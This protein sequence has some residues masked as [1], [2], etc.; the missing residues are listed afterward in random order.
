MIKSFEDKIWFNCTFE[1][2]M[3]LLEIS[4][5]LLSLPL[6]NAVY[7]LGLISKDHCVYLSQKIPA[8][9]FLVISESLLIHFR[10][11]LILLLQFDGILLVPAYLILQLF[12]LLL[13]GD[14]SK[15]LSLPF[16]FAILQLELQALNLL[17][18]L[19]GLGRSILNVLLAFIN[20]LLKLCDFLAC[21]IELVI[22]LLSLELE[23]LS[24]QFILLL[25]TFKLVY[26]LL[27]L[28]FSGL[29][30]TSFFCLCIIKV[31][32]HLTFQFSNFFL[33]VFFS[34]S[35]GWDLLFGVVKLS[36]NVGKCL[37]IISVFGADFLFQPGYLSIFQN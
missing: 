15:F 20:D 27:S 7:Y 32:F 5:D 33:I 14:I 11:L 12:K 13:G 1:F 3:N 30:P 21:L 24:K 10:I 26:K 31:I 17:S 36:S 25:H 18:L 16:L 4:K 9:R 19:D 6:P 29:L 2:L 23:L 35:P 22:H 28:V 34:L 8:L 37:L